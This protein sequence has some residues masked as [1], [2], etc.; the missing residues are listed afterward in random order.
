MNNP[1]CTFSYLYPDPFFPRLVEGNPQVGVAVC[2]HRLQADAILLCEVQVERLRR[3]AV[4]DQH[5][6]AVEFEVDGDFFVSLYL[7][8][9]IT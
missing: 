1:V 9:A 5:A 8:S 2:R 6:T 3:Q 7:Q 4:V